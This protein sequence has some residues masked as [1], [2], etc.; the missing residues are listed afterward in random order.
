MRLGIEHAVSVDELCAAYPL[1]DVIDHDKSRAA[2]RITQHLFL[3]YQLF[4]CLWSSFF[5][6]VSTI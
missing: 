5:L 1:L 4:I 6:S 2:V 3:F